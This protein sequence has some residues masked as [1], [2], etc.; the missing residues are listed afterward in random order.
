[1][2]ETASIADQKGGLGMASDM[3]VRNLPA[4]CILAAAIIFGSFLVFKQILA[5][6]RARIELAQENAKKQPPPQAVVPAQSIIK[7]PETLKVEEIKRDVESADLLE[8]YD[9]EDN[10]PGL[11]QI[12]R[13]GEQ[14]LQK[15]VEGVEYVKAVLFRLQVGAARILADVTLY[16]DT[17]VPVTPRFQIILFNQK[18]RYIGRDTV[19]YITDEL[20]AG[21]KK[22]E[23]LSFSANPAGVAYFE[24]R[25]L[26]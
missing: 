5:V 1:V 7:K 12:F 9:K 6:Q 4:L 2:K 22:T 10:K 19:L 11:I 21:E 25:K 16:N 18:G 15:K 8:T 3:N 26:D 24:V 14:L 17:G 23:T 13:M 20:V